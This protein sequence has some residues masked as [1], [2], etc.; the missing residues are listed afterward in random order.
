MPGPVTLSSYI[1]LYELESKAQ[2]VL[3]ALVI[4]VSLI[5]ALS[6]ARCSL[7]QLARSKCSTRARHPRFH[8]H[9]PVPIADLPLLSNPLYASRFDI[10]VIQS[11]IIR[12]FTEP[13]MYVGREAK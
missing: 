4:C 1:Q 12:N 3:P 9:D 7:S 10:S 8:T 6:D 2:A 13:T 11:P 5:I